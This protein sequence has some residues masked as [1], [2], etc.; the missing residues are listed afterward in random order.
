MF[1]KRKMPLLMCYFFAVN[2]ASFCAWNSKVM[3]LNIY[4]FSR[5]VGVACMNPARAFGPAVVTGG[6]A[7]NRHWLLWISDLTGA[8]IAAGFYM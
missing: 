6:P 7:W 1:A 8:I 2:I 3:Q 5:W 4:F